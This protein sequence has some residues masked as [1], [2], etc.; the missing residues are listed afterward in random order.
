MFMFL[1]FLLLIK[2]IFLAFFIFPLYQLFQRQ[3]TLEMVLYSITE[4]IEKK[5]AG[6]FEQKI[7]DNLFG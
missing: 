3:A 1:F 2:K 5:H 7:E 6:N 4:W